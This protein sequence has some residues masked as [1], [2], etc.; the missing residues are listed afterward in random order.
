[1]RSPGFTRLAHESYIQMADE[2]GLPGLLALLLTL[3][4]TFAA[5]L[6]RPRPS[7]PPRPNNGEPEG[8]VGG[9]FLS[10]VAAADDQVLRCGLLGGLAAGVVQNLI[11]S[12]WYVF[13]LGV[14]FWTLAGLAAGLAPPELG[15]GGRPDAVSGRE[16]GAAMAVGAAS[17]LVRMATQGIAATYDQQATA[18]RREARLRRPPWPSRAGPTPDAGTR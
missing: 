11:D 9:Q 3:G 7:Q 17:I 12:D 8:S 4:F 13:F 5:A 14:T 10:F 2:C 6:S 18:R 16:C 15:A 1:M